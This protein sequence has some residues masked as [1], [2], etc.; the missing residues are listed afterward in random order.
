MQ[1]GFKPLNHHHMSVQS[2]TCSLF[3]VS[4]CTFPCFIRQPV[5]NKLKKHKRGRKKIKDPSYLR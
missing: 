5:L 2:F 3:P 4:R 1:V